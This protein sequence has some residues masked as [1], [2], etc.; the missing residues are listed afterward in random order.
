MTLTIRRAGKGPHGWPLLEVWQGAE[1]VSSHEVEHPEAFI[2]LVRKN[3][4][5]E[6]ADVVV[7]GEGEG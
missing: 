1:L 5:E 6:G 3:A 2:E 4:R 7:E